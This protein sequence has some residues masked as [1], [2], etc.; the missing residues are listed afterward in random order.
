MAGCSGES[1]KPQKGHAGLVQDGVG[2]L[3]DQAGEKLRQQMGQDMPPD[4]PPPGDAQLFRGP[5]IGRLPQLQH[6]A[7]DDPAQRGPMAQGHARDHPRE[8]PAERQRNQHHQE[9]VGNPHH[10]IHAPRE[11]RVHLGPQQGRGD[12]NG[13]GNHRAD[14]GGENPNPDAQGQAGSTSGPA[15]PGPSSPSRRDIAGRAPGFSARSRSASPGPPGV[16]PPPPPRTGARRRCR[17]GAAP[18]FRL[19]HAFM[20]A[21]PPFGSSGPPRHRAGRAIRLPA[22]TMAAVTTVMPSSRGR[23]LPSPASTAT[24]PRPG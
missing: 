18:F 6:L 13:Q 22:K 23:S 12:S 16:S 24:C 10:Q 15:C 20:T 1:P 3:K 17:K 5:H 8:S 21:P 2:E 7:P 19:F 9:D 14:R 11:R 4:H